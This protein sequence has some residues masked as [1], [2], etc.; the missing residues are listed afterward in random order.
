MTILFSASPFI[1][2]GDAVICEG[3]CALPVSGAGRRAIALAPTL[4]G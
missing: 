3:L 2:A 4:D 1:G